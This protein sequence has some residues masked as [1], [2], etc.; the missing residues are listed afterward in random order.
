M[1]HPDSTEASTYKSLKHVRNGNAEASG[2]E[3]K[4]CIKA[5]LCVDQSIIEE[6]EPV[7]GEPA[8]VLQCQSLVAALA[9]EPAVRFPQRV[10]STH[11]DTFSFM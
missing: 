3:S 4:L 5:H 10:L 6:D 9:D 1:P 2:C 11:K 7:D 8:S